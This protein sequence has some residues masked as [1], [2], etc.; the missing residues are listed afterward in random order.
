M[1]LLNVWHRRTRLSTF[2]TF[3]KNV[4]VGST[5]AAGVIEMAQSIATE[6]S[7]STEVGHLAGLQTKS[8]AERDYLRLVRKDLCAA[9]TWKIS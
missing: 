3:V 5:S 6:G 2:E 8:H 1:P 9:Y 4:G 7:A